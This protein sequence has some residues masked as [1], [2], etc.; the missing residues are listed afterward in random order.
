MRPAKSILFT[1]ITPPQLKKNTLQRQSLNK[2]LKQVFEYPLTI[3]QSG[4]GYGKSTA[5]SSFFRME[6][7]AVCWYS[8][9]EREDDLVPFFQYL[10]QA[11]RTEYPNFGEQI[12][13]SLIEGN[14]GSDEQDLY[15]LSDTF[16]NELMMVSDEVVV[17]IDDYHLVEHSVSVS[18]SL[19]YMI[20]HLPQQ[21]HLVLSGR[22]K[23]QWEALT[24][25]KVKAELL[26]IG[27]SDLAFSAEEIEV[28]FADYYELALGEAEVQAIYKKTEGWVMAVQMIWQQLTLGRKLELILEHDGHSMDDLF[29]YLAMEVFSKQSE[30]IRDALLRTCIFD[31]FHA[32]LCDKLYGWHESH[33]LLDRI[34]SLRLFLFQTGEHQY[35]YHAMFRE[36]LVQRLKSEDNRFRFLHE[37]AARYYIEYQQPESALYHYQ[38]ISDQQG[39]AAVLHHHGKM[40]VKTGRLSKLLEL[41]NTLAYSLMDHYVWLWVYQGEAYRY[42]CLYDKAQTCYERAKQL[43]RTN[44][45][46]QI[47]AAALEGQAR[48]FLDTI[49]PRKADALLKESLELIES[50]DESTTDVKEDRLRLYSLLAENLVNSGRAAD[51]EHWVVRCRELD[52]SFKEDVLEIRMNLRSGKL[53]T[54]LRLLEKLKEEETAKGGLILS[55]SHRELMI[56]TSLIE[57]MIGYPEKAKAA[58]QE[59]M[60][61]G[62]RT[63]S[64]F[65]EACGWMRMGHAAQ[66]LSNVKFDVA[67]GCYRTSQEMMEGLE[68]SRG[69]AELSWVYVC[70]MGEPDH[71]NPLFS[72]AEWLCR[73]LNKSA[74]RGCLPG[75]V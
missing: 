75:F 41:T 40:L 47:Q 1:K 16:L 71:S 32:S 25:M 15:V 55:R 7:I 18:K 62:I 35:R 4:P 70:F 14:Y 38:M 28:L 9:G 2:R 36:F 51:A 19:E 31:D 60:L 43:A 64:P 46:I 24:S 13:D 10:V 65:A 63:E 22:T 44:G 8:C 53:S 11:I 66:L 67:L 5:L 23:P 20:R 52:P 74:M 73:K 3:V 68:V 56:I 29:R 33:V 27:E 61:Q 39:I 50:L 21:V 26:E 59:G 57:S 12:I 17:V 49:Q 58:A 30:E 45:D 72:M 54:A 48:V 69:K 34:C 6:R 42:R 37:G